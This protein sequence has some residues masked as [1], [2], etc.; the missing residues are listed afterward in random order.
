MDILTVS[1]AVPQVPR[2]KTARIRTAMQC[3]A[4]TVSFLTMVPRRAN[5][6]AMSRGPERPGLSGPPAGMGERGA[7]IVRLQDPPDRLS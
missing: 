1:V 7:S 3:S 5:G 6:S 4:V 2:M